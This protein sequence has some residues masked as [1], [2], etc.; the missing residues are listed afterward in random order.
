[1]RGAARR[2]FP[3]Q[4]EEPRLANLNDDLVWRGD[5]S[6]SQAP[7]NEVDGLILSWLSYAEWDGIVPGDGGDC[8]L[9]DAAAA[10][11]RLR[12]RPAQSQAFSVNA[13]AA[14]AVLVGRLCDCPRYRPLRLSAFVN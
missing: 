6:F 12:P 4:K 1:M 10:V 14:A 7:L 5:L 8:S 11:L 3:H 2:V 9:A 13:A